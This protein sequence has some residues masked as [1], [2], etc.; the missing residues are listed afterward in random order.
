[1]FRHDQVTDLGLNFGMGMGRNAP[2]ALP[3]DPPLGMTALIFLFL[4]FIILCGY[5]FILVVTYFIYSIT[6]N[7]C[8]KY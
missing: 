6:N 8:L 3:L 1:M 7:I 2:F 4:V 5:K